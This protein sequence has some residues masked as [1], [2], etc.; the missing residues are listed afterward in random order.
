MKYILSITLVLILSGCNSAF[1]RRAQKN[2][3]IEEIIAFRQYLVTINIMND[4]KEYKIINYENSDMVIRDFFDKYKIKYMYIIPCKKHHPL[5]DPFKNCGNLVQL[6]Y[7]N[8]PFVES[9]H[10]IYFDYSEEGLQL[11]DG[12]PK[13]VMVADRIYVL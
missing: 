12:W 13:S 5:S 9:N 8:L 3:N 11:K 7:N 1:E 4:F 6:S 2:S 10:A